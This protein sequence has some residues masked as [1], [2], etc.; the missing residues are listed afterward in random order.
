MCLIPRTYTPV[1]VS[2]FPTCDFNVSDSVSVS[3]LRRL[4]SKRNSAFSVRSDLISSSSLLIV[5]CS[6]VAWFEIVHLEDNRD[7]AGHLVFVDRLFVAMLSYLLEVV[8]CH[9]EET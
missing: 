8:S 9:A 6:V 2:S 1:C 3:V 7:Y 4:T 5:F